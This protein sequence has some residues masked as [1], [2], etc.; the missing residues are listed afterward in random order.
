MFQNVSEYF[1]T[2]KNKETKEKKKD[3]TIEQVKSSKPQ[4][5]GQENATSTFNIIKKAKEKS[6][7]ELLRE[8]NILKL[9]RKIKE[10]GLF[11]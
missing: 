11:D 10:L 9:K 1:K 4:K 5:E 2:R 3:K 7:Y 6:E 8:R